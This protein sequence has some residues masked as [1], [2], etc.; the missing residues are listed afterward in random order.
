MV[1]QED[2][3]E[4]QSRYNAV[5]AERDQL[6]MQVIDMRIKGL[7]ISRDDH[8]ERIRV[9]EPIA[10]RNTFLLATIS[11]IAG[12]LLTVIIRQVIGLP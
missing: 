7:E 3:E 8:E 9:L 11:G 4:L 6:H 5:T 1:S 2:Y 10:S 12:S